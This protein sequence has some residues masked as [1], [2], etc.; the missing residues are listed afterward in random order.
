MKNRETS[1]HTMADRAQISQALVTRPAVVLPTEQ[2]VESGRVFRHSTATTL[3][4][5]SYHTDLEK[6]ANTPEIQASSQSSAS[7][8]TRNSISWEK[9]ITT[10]A[11]NGTRL[12][13]F[14]RHTLFTIYR[15]IFSLVF[16]GNLAALVTVLVRRGPTGWPRVSDVGT[17]VS[18]NLAAS[19]LIREEH[20]INVIFAAFCSLPLSTPLF[21]RR[22]SAKV[23]HLGGLH[24]GC[25]VASLCWF[26]VF[27]GAITR[28]FITHD[29]HREMVREPAVLVVTHLI[30]ALLITIV[31]LALPRFRALYHNSFEAVHRFGG[32][33]TLVLF[34]LQVIFVTDATRKATTRA[35]LGRALAVDPSFWLLLAATCSI[36]SSWTRLRRVKVNA[37]VLS[38][39]ALRLDFAYAAAG[40]GSAVRLSDTPLREWHA[41][42][43]FSKPNS[44][45]FSVVVSNAGDWTKKQVQS[46]PTDIWVRGIPTS[47]VLRVATVF[48]KI[49][50]VATGSGIGPCLSVIYSRQVP[51]R[52]LWSTPHPLETFGSEI[53]NAVTEA[54]PQAIIHN[55]RTMG[56]P[57]MVALTYQLYVESQAEAVV[58]ISNPSLT[59]KV[60]YG[61]ESRGSQPMDPFGTPDSP[62]KREQKRYMYIDLIRSE[63]WAIGWERHE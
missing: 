23:Y 28:Q 11:K 6:R 33:S 12:Q 27:A 26:I 29:S 18:A 51:C 61:M 24:S 36:I 58:V 3:G 54:D 25:A 49:V 4:G 39:H 43:A 38:D 63:R 8:S 42:A 52:V 44:S 2:D 21:L 22:L 60:V 50:L 62:R 32:W 35:S 5:T 56:K 31:V 37:E 30:L 55:T 47:G 53:T 13:R 17:A 59:R 20:I 1:S 40:V 10:P 19:I 34:W 15:R 14:L 46:P 41:F 7:C 48:R 16:L 57:D 45:G 9:R